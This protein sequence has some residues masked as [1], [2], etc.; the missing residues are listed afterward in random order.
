MAEMRLEDHKPAVKS[1][2]QFALNRLLQDQ[3]AA[4]PPGE[5]GV[6]PPEPLVKPRKIAQAGAFKQVSF[7]WYEHVSHY[8]SS[9]NAFSGEQMSWYFAFLAQHSGTKTSP[10]ECLEI[11]RKAALPPADAQL[12]QNEYVEQGDEQYFTAA[13]QH[14]HQGVPVERDYLQVLVNGNTGAVFSYARKWRKVDTSAGAR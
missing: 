13:W 4:T 3:Q 5:P 1:A 11:A 14:V 9:Y 12:E 7:E 6:S 10:K 8:G 2:R